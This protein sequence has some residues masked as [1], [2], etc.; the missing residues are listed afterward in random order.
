MPLYDALY[1]HCPI[2]EIPKVQ[3]IMRKVLSEENG[4]DLPGGYLRFNLDSD[5]DSA[6]GVPLSKEQAEHIKQVL[7]ARGEEFHE[8]G[9]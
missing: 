5:V 3:K 2:D 6:C 8:H 1:V 4:W 7:A 9:W